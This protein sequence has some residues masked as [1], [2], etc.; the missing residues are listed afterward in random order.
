MNTSSGGYA[1]KIHNVAKAVQRIDAGVD[2]GNVSTV[3]ASY[4]DLLRLRKKL[5]GGGVLR[6]DAATQKDLSSTREFDAWARDRYPVFNDSSLG[7]DQPSATSH[8]FVAFLLG[9]FVLLFVV[10]YAGFSYVC[11]S[12]IA[13]VVLIILTVAAF[14]YFRR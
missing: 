8:G 11:S 10:L 4:Q 13:L 1:R 12:R 5:E 9:P 7:T 3:G 14:I 2:Y 6:V